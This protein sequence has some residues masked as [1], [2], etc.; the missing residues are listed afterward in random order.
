VLVEHARTV[1]GVVDASHRESSE[2]GDPVVSLLACSLA[3][4]T[5][6]IA[7]VPGTRTAALYAPRTEATERTTCN[8]GL[9]PA[10]AHI[11]HEGG[12]AVTATDGTGEVRAIERTDH[13]FFVATLFQPQLS[14]SAGAPHPLWSGFV[15]ACARA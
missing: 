11:A 12:L 7:I 15:A 9:N 6:E 1:L 2:D 5:I 10:F 4:D 8:Y 14:S 13:P 3:D